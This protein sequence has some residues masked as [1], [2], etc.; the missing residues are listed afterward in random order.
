MAFFGQESFECVSV[1]GIRSAAMPAVPPAMPHCPMVV[2]SP[3]SPP[4]MHGV[5]T[6]RAELRPLRQ[7]ASFDLAFVGNEIIAEPEGVGHAK[8]ARIAPVLGS[9]V[10]R[11]GQKHHHRQRQAE[12]ETQS[13]HVLLP[14]D[15]ITPGL[16]SN[17]ST[18]AARRPA[19]DGPHIRAKVK[20]ESE[21]ENT[22][23]C[24]VSVPRKSPTTGSS[25]WSR[26]CVRNCLP[27]PRSARPWRCRTTGG[28]K[29]ARRA[30]QG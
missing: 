28:D 11:A 22:A 14:Q 24:A 29:T 8:F 21:L 23:I 27:R 4:R 12:D 30:S 18:L 9:G 16:R 26:D 17:W 7:H 2:V 13:P 5:A 25:V 10:V 3:A 20:S 15:F 6:G 19:V 1:S